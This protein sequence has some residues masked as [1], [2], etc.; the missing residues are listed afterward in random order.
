MAMRGESDALTWSGGT[1]VELSHT[2]EQPAAGSDTR[3]TKSFPLIM[4][5]EGTRLR[6]VGFHDG[7]KEGSRLVEIGLRLN[8]EITLVQSSGDG[9]LLIGVSDLRLSVDRLIAHRILVELIAESPI[10]NVPA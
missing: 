3:E 8:R 6:V 4:A 9:P 10:M 2:G 5:R 7:C 1:L